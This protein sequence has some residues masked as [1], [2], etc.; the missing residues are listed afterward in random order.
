VRGA[1]G[2]GTVGPAGPVGRT[3]PQGPAGDAGA[4]GPTLVGPAGPAGRSG[5]AGQQGQAG[6]IGAQ[7]GTT[8]GIAGAAGAA[9]EAGPQ[10]QA[11]PIGPQGSTGI[12][13]RWTEYR[14][15]WF[16]AE[17]DTIHPADQAKVTEIATYMNDNP[18]L[19]IGIDSSMNTNSAD[20]SNLSLATRRG[21]AVHNALVQ[22]GVSADRIT[23]GTFGNVD[24][25]RDGR[26]EVLFKTDHLSHSQHGLL[27]PTGVVEHWTTYRDFRFDSGKAIIHPADAAKVADIA[28][29]IKSNPT[30]QVG[31]DSSLDAQKLNQQSVDLS[32]RRT[33]AIRN[34]LVAA[35]VP[36]SSIRSGIFGDT[37]LRR[38]GRVE[39]LVISEQFATRQ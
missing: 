36:A 34:A 13:Q 25:R 10:G 3:G 15:F 11:G 32:K 18:S 27:G 39:V 22:G 37:R 29:Y 7:G 9:G 35:G 21:N 5:V 4:K 24:F 8:A 1:S 17:T 26:V 28:A 20:Q 33:A 12:V 19:Q 23:T 2:D 16:E 38:D 14:E 6:Q 31:I 30:M